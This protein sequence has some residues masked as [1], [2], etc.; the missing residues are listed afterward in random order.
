[1]PMKLT[2]SSALL[3]TALAGYSFS[4]KAVVAQDTTSPT[5]AGPAD[6]DDHGRAT[7]YKEFDHALRKDPQMAEEL[8]KNPS[9]MNDP[10]YL[11]KHPGLQKY[12]NTHPDMAKAAQSNPDRLLGSVHRSQVKQQRQTRERRHEEMQ[13]K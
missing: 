10:A 11:A 4:P 12:M 13:P 8:K 5:S 3:F 1:M 2:V 9:L 7:S 6:T